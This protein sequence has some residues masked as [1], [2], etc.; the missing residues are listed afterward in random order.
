MTNY[1]SIIKVI[2]IEIRDDCISVEFSTDSQRE[3]ERERIGCI[4][5]INISNNVRVRVS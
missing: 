1:C 5:S 3:T 4:S 2:E